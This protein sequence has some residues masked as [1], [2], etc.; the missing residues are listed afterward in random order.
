MKIDYEYLKKMLDVFYQSETPYIT[1]HDFESAGLDEDDELFLFYMQ[2]M[3]DKNLIT[4]KDGDG[5]GYCLGSDGVSWGATDLRLTDIGYDFIS[6]LEQADVWNV[7]EK[8][9]KAESINTIINVS[10]D[11]ALNFAKKKAEKYLKDI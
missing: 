2:I 11:L 7:I 10:K 6:A 1:I 3:E 5:L 9:F 4:S 8:K